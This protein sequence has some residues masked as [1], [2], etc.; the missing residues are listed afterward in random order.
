MIGRERKLDGQT[1]QKKR[2]A[3]LE[4]KE[5]RWVKK[6]RSYQGRFEACFNRKS[7]V[8]FRLVDENWFV[9]SPCWYL[10]DF[11]LVERRE[12]DQIVLVK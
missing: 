9:K 1:R 10:F 2:K 12:R 5:M 7:L 11:D 3:K 4:E 8:Y 6:G